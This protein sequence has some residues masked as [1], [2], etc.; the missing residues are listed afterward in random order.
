VV[1]GAAAVVRHRAPITRNATEFLPSSGN[2]RQSTIQRT[3]VML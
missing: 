3:I 1:V 2:C